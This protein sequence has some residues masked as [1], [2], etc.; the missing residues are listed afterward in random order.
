MKTNYTYPA[1]IKK[2]E[3]GI[4]L[5]FIDFPENI[6]YADDESTLIENAQQALALTLLDH[7]DQKIDIP[8][9]SMQQTDVVYIQ[10]W[11]PFYRNM[12]K[13]VYIKKTV[14]IPQW[15]DLLAKENNI[16]FSAC[17]VDGIKEKLGI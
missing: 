8:A 7:I 5:Q 9:P 2:N 17:M 11:L 4:Q 16:N 15:L 3:N 12:S 1:K 14:T 13:E 6:V 10:V